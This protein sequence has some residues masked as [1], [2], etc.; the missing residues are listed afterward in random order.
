MGGYIEKKQKKENINNF[1][2]SSLIIYSEPY[3]MLKMQK[4]K[5]A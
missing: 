4:I 2:N 5:N 3:F 1:T